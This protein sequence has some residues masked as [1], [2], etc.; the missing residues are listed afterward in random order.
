MFISLQIKN[1]QIINFNLPVTVLKIPALQNILVTSLHIRLQKIKIAIESINHDNLNLANF[2]ERYNISYESFADEFTLKQCNL[3]VC[4]QKISRKITML[5]NFQV[6]LN[7]LQIYHQKSETKLD[8][9]L[10]HSYSILNF[11]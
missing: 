2:T 11:D 6:Q 8:A 9:M 7:I 4:T 10:V 3:E 5:K 1:A